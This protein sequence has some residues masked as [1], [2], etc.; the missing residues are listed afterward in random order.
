MDRGAIRNSDNVDLRVVVDS[1]L[2]FFFIHQS[3]EEANRLIGF[4]PRNR[5]DF[6][7][8]WAKVLSDDDIV[9]QTIVA[10]GEVA[11]DIV[12]FLQSGER[13]VEYWLGREFWGRGIATKALAA[14]LVQVPERPLFAHV[15]KHNYA[16]HRVLEKCGFVVVGEERSIS[17]V[18][19]EVVEDWVV[20]VD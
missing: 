12:C 5:E 15:A 18:T 13:E 8:H 19:N 1:D 2:E 7:T 4:A 20:R 17:E 6:K 9:K 10:G 14:F 16:S 11:G 3:D